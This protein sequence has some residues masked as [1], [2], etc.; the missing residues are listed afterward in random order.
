VTSGFQ[1]LVDTGES[2]RRIRF[3]S[4]GSFY[5]FE[6]LAVARNGRPGSSTCFIGGNAVD[7]DTGSAMAGSRRRHSGLMD[8][9]AWT[10]RQHR[11]LPSGSSPSPPRSDIHEKAAHPSA[12]LLQRHCLLYH[13]SQ[14]S[15][16]GSNWLSEFQPCLHL[17]E[18]GVLWPDLLDRV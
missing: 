17:D 8:S 15:D 2:S 16:R 18:L 6:S 13:R 3:Q 7:G 14:S 9:V 10:N 11:G 4:F 12:S 1:G 5:T